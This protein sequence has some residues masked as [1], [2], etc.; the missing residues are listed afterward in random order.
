VIVIFF[1]SAPAA[2]ETLCLPELPGRACTERAMRGRFS[3]SHKMYGDRGSVGRLGSLIA[4]IVMLGF[5]TMLFMLNKTI[6]YSIRKKIKETKI[7]YFIDVDPVIVH[8]CFS[9][10]NSLFGWSRR[11]FW[12]SMIGC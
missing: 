2:F 12:L 5:A 3:R 4:L 7:A 9:A 10:A 6:V 1:H 11:V 8:G